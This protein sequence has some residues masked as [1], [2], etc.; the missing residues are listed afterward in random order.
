LFSAYWKEQLTFAINNF[1]PVLLTRRYFLFFGRV[2]I[3]STL[4]RVAHEQKRKRP[5]SAVQIGGLS[6]EIKESRREK[7]VDDD[8]SQGERSKSAR[9][10]PLE[11][12]AET[13]LYYPHPKPFKISS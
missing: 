5:F 1:S 10:W 2:L 13:Y 3:T 7:R 9:R 11:L 4:E 12:D 6:H 8:L